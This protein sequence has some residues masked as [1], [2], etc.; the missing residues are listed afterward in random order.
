MRRT[1]DNLKMLVG[2]INQQLQ[3][4]NIQTTYTIEL[5]NGI[6]TVRNSVNEG[7]CDGTLRDCE[8][9]LVSVNHFINIHSALLMP[10]DKNRFEMNVAVE[11]G[12]LD[13]VRRN[14]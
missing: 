9:Y 2:L 6:Y 14:K 5:S 10:V 1:F 8:I 4:L 13:W 11:D 3:S 7:K 12:D